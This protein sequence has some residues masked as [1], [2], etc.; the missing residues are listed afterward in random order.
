MLGCCQSSLDYYRLAQPTFDELLPLEQLR[1]AL[2][3]ILRPAFLATDFVIC[4]VRSLSEQDSISEPIKLV[5]S[6]DG[7]NFN[8]PFAKAQVLAV[9]V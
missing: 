7:S 2:I 3:E 1:D 8:A 9:E 4:N 6:H 5:T